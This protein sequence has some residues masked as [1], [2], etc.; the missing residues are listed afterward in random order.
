MPGSGIWAAA[1]P[2]GRTPSSLD[3]GVQRGWLE[4][5][6]HERVVQQPGGAGDRCGLELR[7]ALG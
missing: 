4:A 3:P 2:T 6:S 1:S 7:Q 5:G